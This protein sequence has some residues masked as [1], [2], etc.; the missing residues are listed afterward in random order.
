MKSI[1]FK[2]L[3]IILWTLPLACTGSSKDKPDAESVT[4]QTDTSDAGDFDAIVDDVVDEDVESAED[5]D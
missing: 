4:Q 1:L 5:K 2:L 3:V